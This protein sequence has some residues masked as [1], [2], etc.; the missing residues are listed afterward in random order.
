MSIPNNRIDR[1]QS[2]S[3]QISGQAVPLVSDSNHVEEPKNFAPKQPVNLNPPKD[4]PITQSQLTKCDG[5]DPSRPTLV[6]IKGTC[7][8]V[9]GNKAYGVGGQYHGRLRDMSIS[10][11]AFPVQGVFNTEVG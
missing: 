5:T 7:F 11:R 9:S 3:R 1:S 10:F 4:D 8:D 6:A 2:L